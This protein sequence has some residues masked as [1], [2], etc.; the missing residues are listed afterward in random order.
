M[1]YPGK[2]SMKV[3]NSF[4]P[5]ILSASL[6]LAGCRETVVYTIYNN[7]P[8]NLIVELT[9]REVDWVAGKPLRMDKD[10]L[11]R[12]R[13]VNEEGQD[14]PV[15]SIRRDDVAGHYR[16]TSPGYPIPTEYAGRRRG[17]ILEYRFQLQQDWNLYLM[18]PEDSYPA[19]GR[20]LRLQPPGFPIGR[21][22][23]AK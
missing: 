1:H 3:V 16:F 14:Y 12:I 21:Y 7:T 10:M 6:L 9:D 15:L 8:W 13:W 17:G 11:A 4:K 2:S 19:P 23:I 5:L 22:T 20:H 18:R